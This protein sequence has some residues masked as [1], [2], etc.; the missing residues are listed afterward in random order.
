MSNEAI[1]EAI[2]RAN[3]SRR[4]ADCPGVGPALA[5]AGRYR[6]QPKGLSISVQFLGL[7]WARPEAAFERGQRQAWQYQQTRGPLSAQPVR[8]R[9]ARR[10]PLRQDP[11]YQAAARGSRRYWRG[12]RP[13]LPNL[14]K[15]PRI[16]TAHLPPASTNA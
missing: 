12:A 14:P 8:C 6:C 2:A 5:T 16:Q 15:G 13:R 7:D 1:C 4:L 11:W 9:R 3:I 10:H